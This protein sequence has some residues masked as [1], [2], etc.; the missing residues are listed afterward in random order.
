MSTDSPA[1]EQGP[2]NVETNYF[3]TVLEHFTADGNLRTSTTTIAIMC[4]VCAGKKL[5]I[6]NP[7]SRPRPTQET[8][9]SYTVLR[10]GHAFGYECLKTWLGYNATCPTCRTP[11]TCPR[12]HGHKLVVHGATLRAADQPQ[13]I[14][15][16][17]E[18]LEDDQDCE[19][20]A[21]ERRG[22]RQGL[23]PGLLPPWNPLDPSM[24]EFYEP[25]PRL[26]FLFE[27]SN[28]YRNIRPPWTYE[29]PPGFPGPSPGTPY[30]IGS[31]SRTASPVRDFS[32][33]DPILD[34]RTPPNTR[35]EHTVGP[36]WVVPLPELPQ[37]TD[38]AS[39]QGPSSPN[40][41]HRRR[42]RHSR[43]DHGGL[44]DDVDIVDVSATGRP[45]VVSSP[46]PPPRRRSRTTYFD[47]NTNINYSDPDA[48]GYGGANII[49]VSPTRQRNDDDH[50][51]RRRRR[52][53]RRDGGERVDVDDE[54]DASP[55]P[56]PI[57]HYHPNSSSSIV[58]PSSSSREDADVAA[59]E[60]AIG[61]VIPRDDPAFELEITVHRDGGI[62][63]A[64][65]GTTA[66]SWRLRDAAAADS[67]DND[68]VE[69]GDVDRYYRLTTDAQGHHTLIRQRLEPVLPTPTTSTPS[70]S[71]RSPAGG[72]SPTVSS[73]GYRYVRSRSGGGGVGHGYGGRQ[74]LHGV[75]DRNGDGGS[76][77]SGH[78]HRRHR[79][80]YHDDDDDD[81]AAIFATRSIFGGDQSQSLRALRHAF[82]DFTLRDE[83]E[84]EQEQEGEY[85][86]IAP[87]T[88]WPQSRSWS[89][90]WS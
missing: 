44:G 20:C 29:P 84:E 82:D 62:S 86:A 80:L 52:R 85:R 10:C 2:V 78:R 5:A 63:V 6:V 76:H 59:I 43:R 9:E 1:A 31:R 70:S 47:Y 87:P 3:G 21:H 40:S 83:E 54:A 46:P 18:V 48:Y 38:A 28:T 57:H 69:E 71:S 33:P 15:L 90:S 74:L 64:A 30:G 45:I 37:S 51:R 19:R 65:P 68:E 12:G 42:R 35:P 67:N 89:W 27:S 58:P 23:F 34:Y 61:P 25:R 13:D 36:P 8:H 49:D 26:D 4:V 66:V 7:D 55:P 53:H 79:S 14:R 16:I 39:P 50:R 11:T 73:N 60:S 24:P 72:Q 32:L 81:D 75:R 77:S 88:T 41:R 17:R 56:G 22:S